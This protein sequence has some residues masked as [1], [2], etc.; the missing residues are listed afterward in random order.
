VNLLVDHSA[1]NTTSSSAEGAIT[2]NDVLMQL[3]ADPQDPDAPRF[4]LE[5]AIQTALVQA[6]P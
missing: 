3:G 6:W 5:G 1:A 2:A 4:F